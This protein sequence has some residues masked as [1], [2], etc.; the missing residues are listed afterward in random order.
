MKILQ[1]ICFV[2][3]LVTFSSVYADQMNLETGEYIM[4]MGGGDQMNLETGEYNMDMGGGDQMNLETGEYY[5]N[6]D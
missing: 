2:L 6:L 3:L 1:K 4:D 5:M